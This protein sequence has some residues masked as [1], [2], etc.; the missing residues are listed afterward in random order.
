MEYGI[1]GVQTD[2]RGTRHPTTILDFPQKWRRQDQL[3]PTQKPVEL[4]EWLIKSYCPV[5]GIVLDNCMGAGST[6]IAASKTSRKFIGIEK[7]EK[8]FNIAK[9]RLLKLN[10]G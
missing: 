9:E 8:Y 1:S 5:E 6:C 10:G 2:N 4:L 3:H 7:E